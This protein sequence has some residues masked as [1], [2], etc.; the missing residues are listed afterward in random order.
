MFIGIQILRAKVRG[1][2]AAGETIHC[3]IR[4]SSGKKRESLWNE[5]RKLGNCSRLHLIAYGLLRGVSY[6]RI[7]H[8][9]KTNLPNVSSL[10][11]VMV[12]HATYE[13]RKELTFARVKE[14]LEGSTLALEKRLVK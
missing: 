12:E 6:E 11:A 13:Q 4:K 7:E 1:F 14:L 8:C 9:A 2:H 3:R 5:K 10:L